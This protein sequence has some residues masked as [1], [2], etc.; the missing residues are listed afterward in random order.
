MIWIFLFSILSH[1]GTMSFVDKTPL[2]SVPE[3]SF[4]ITATEWFAGWSAVSDSSR[5]FGENC[6]PT[7]SGSP[8]TWSL[9]IQDKLVRCDKTWRVSS[10]GPLGINLKIFDFQNR[11][12]EDPRFRGVEFVLSNGTKVRGLLGL[13]E[14][15]EP[16]PLIVFRCG[17]FCNS[18]RAFA[19][20]YLI[21]HYFGDSPFHF[22][23]V[24]SSTSAERIETNSA[25][26]AGGY[27]EAHE[28]FEILEILKQQQPD[29]MKR[30]ASS[31]LVGVSLGGQSVLLSHAMPKAN[32]FS[33]YT[34]L[35][36]IVQF[37]ETLGLMMKTK[38]KAYFIGL[39]FYY[40]LNKAFQ[41]DE[42]LDSQMKEYSHFNFQKLGKNIAGHFPKFL[43][44]PI[45]E[46][47]YWRQNN[48]IEAWGSWEKPLSTQPLMVIGSGN[49][50][51]P[52][53]ANFVKL[54]PYFS[55]KNPQFALIEF[56]DSA[57]C[58]F[59]VTHDWTLISKILHGFVT[60]N[61]S[62]GLAK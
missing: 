12:W 46:E 50:S 19:E 45:D 28:N 33:S 42:H 21:Q 57:H 56:P 14:S 11:Y 49:D 60:H 61:A 30:V 20:K 22:L 2:S 54:K 53:E 15:L 44:K 47:T 31:H 41:F 13:Q 25:F 32:E 26:Q 1:A 40:R 6:D 39:W 37:K 43:N 55:D 9:D 18:T 29:I 23:F 58:G 17:L 48:V 8:R 34:A 24:G 4:F 36:P 52:I 35:C 38:E 10:T 59:S 3:S 51:V 62:A 5:S 27:E 7:V 16:R